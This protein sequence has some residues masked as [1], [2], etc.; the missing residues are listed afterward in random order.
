MAAFYLNDNSVLYAAPSLICKTQKYRRI[1]EECRPILLPFPALPLINQDFRLVLD[2][3]YAEWPPEEWNKIF[4]CIDCGQLYAYNCLDI[5]WPSVTR[6]SESRYRNETNCFFVELKCGHKGCNDVINFYI[7]MHN[8]TKADLERELKKG[9]VG[10][11]PTCGHPAWPH[12]FAPY[13][14]EQ[15]YLGPI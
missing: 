1:D 6:P 12:P 15:V 5:Q 7:E 2:D 10:N 8:K 13:K 11:W 9:F 4:L 3:H 14:I